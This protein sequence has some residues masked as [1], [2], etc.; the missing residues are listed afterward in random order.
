ML[1]VDRQKSKRA[2]A[3]A[4]CSAE[5]GKVDDWINCFC[6]VYQRS[7]IFKLDNVFSKEICSLFR[8]KGKCNG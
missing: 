1:E 2:L 8:V 4:M 7:A 3:C 5:L 6:E